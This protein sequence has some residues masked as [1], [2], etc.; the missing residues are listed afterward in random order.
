MRFYRQTIQS[1]YEKQKG[2]AAYSNQRQMVSPESGLLSR[3]VVGWMSAIR[4]FMEQPS[5]RC[6]D[7]CAGAIRMFME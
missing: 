4:M 5:G 2:K 7:P 3:K 6:S 1:F